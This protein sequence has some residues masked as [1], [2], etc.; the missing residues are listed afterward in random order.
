MPRLALLGEGS[1]SDLF[2]VA[3][4]CVPGEVMSLALHQASG[5]P[6]V[7]IPGPILSTH[8]APP[9]H[10]LNERQFPLNLLKLFSF[11]AWCPLHPRLSS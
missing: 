1:L 5:S 9:S 3:V 4:L 6:H 7:P 2:D 10:P 11:P 8:S